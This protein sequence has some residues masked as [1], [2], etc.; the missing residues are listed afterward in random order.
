MMLKKKVNPLDQLNAR[1][2]E[3]A[4]SHLSYLYY[5]QSW[6]SL[7]AKE[8]WIVNNIKGRYFKGVKPIIN[9]DGSVVV[10]SCIGFENPSDKTLFMIGCP[11]AV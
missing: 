9:D 3:V 7:G 1:R 10:R 2:L 8:T 5:E 11:D 4:G 6:M